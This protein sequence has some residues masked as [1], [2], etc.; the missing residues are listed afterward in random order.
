MFA[1]LNDSLE[2]SNENVGMLIIMTAF[3][4]TKSGT[5]IDAECTSILAP[6]R[7]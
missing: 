2:I 5:R 6:T 1:Q 3:S 7:P 4:V